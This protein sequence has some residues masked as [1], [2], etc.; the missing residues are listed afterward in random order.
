MLRK[1]LLRNQSFLQL[2]IALFG[3]FLG[4]VFLLVSVH[5]LIKV[6]EFGKGSEML[7]ANTLVIQKKVSTTT[8]L[9]L[10][11]TAFSAH[12]I[13]SIQN[14]SFVAD[15]QPVLS[16]NFGVEFA[17]SDPMLPYFRSD[18]FIQSI[19]TRFLDVKSKAWRWDKKS[20]FVPII[21][22]RDFMVMLN[23]FMS[24]SGIP[25]ISDELAKDVQFS[26]RL[27]NNQTDQKFNAKIIGFTNEVSSILV[28]KSFMQFGKNTFGTKSQEKVTQ[29]MISGKEK[30]FG[31]LEKFLNQ[32][33][34]ESKNSQL[35]TGRLKSVVSSLLMVIAFIS[36]LTLLFSS[37]VLI[38]YIQLLISKNAFEVKTLLRLGYTTNSLSKVFITYFV[39][40]FGVLCLLGSLFFI[41]LKS[42]L[43]ER[44]HRTGIYIDLHYTSY[45]WTTLGFSFV[46]FFVL[47]FISSKRTIVNEF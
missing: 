31:L 7:G 42:Y 36:F 15:A 1:I 11:S 30:E 10:A 8:T 19:D 18:V 47:T 22:P 28:P 5:Y 4:V 35:V 3:A 14:K 38:Q 2:I 26:L 16:N 46:L 27:S 20:E 34:Y 21:L 17:T 25:Q 23:T 29:L 6:T 9:Q 37:F 33:H 13:Q 32:Q 12:E 39:T 43:D 45:S 24:S 41:L 40:L 44:L